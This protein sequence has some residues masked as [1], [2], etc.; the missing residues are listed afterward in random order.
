MME[1]EE[2]EEED[3]VSDPALSG[4]LSWS[5]RDVQER[6]LEDEGLLQK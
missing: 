3:W 6:L 1:E 5:V 4:G 2:E